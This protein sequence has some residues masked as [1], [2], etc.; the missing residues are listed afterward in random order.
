MNLCTYH[1]WKT[2]G[3]NHPSLNQSVQHSHPMSMNQQ[4]SLDRNL[5]CIGLSYP[6]ENVNA[7]SIP[8]CVGDDCLNIEAKKFLVIKDCDINNIKDDEVWG[9]L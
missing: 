1:H 2:I 6:E 9:F 4:E 7:S 8:G 3:N 5:K